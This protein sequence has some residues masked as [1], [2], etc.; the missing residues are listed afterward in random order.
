MIEP[1]V[2]RGNFPIAHLI[3]VGQGFYGLEQLRG[4]RTDSVD[5]FAKNALMFSLR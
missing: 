1:I 5:Q 3:P 4:Q 2:E